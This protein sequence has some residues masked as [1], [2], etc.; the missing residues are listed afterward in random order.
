MTLIR[1]G[2]RHGYFT[3]NAPNCDARTEDGFLGSVATAQFPH[4]WTAKDVPGVGMEHY[5]PGHSAQAE[6]PV[7]PA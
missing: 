2:P 6:L 3:C 4:P 1:T 5:C 7:A